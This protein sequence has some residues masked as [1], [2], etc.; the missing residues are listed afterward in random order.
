[1]QLTETTQ[2]QQINQEKKPENNEKQTN[3]KEKDSKDIIIQEYTNQLKRLQ[4]EFENYVKRAEKERTDTIKY[5]NEKLLLK[6]LSVTDNFE[7]AIENIKKTQASS[8]IITGIEI[9]SK[10]FNKILENEGIK[11]INTNRCIFDP[12]LHE[13]V[14]CA[15]NDDCP[16]NMIMQEIQK[17]YTLKNR[18]I[19]YS[20]VIINKPEYT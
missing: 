18:T 1:M 13:A 17:G 12:Y 19:R 8:E 14:T 15:K 2:K 11:P 3:Q 16:E 7:H 6:L 5:A 10:E 20:K 9:V 4:A